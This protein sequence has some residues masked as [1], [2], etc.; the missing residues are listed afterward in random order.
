MYFLYHIPG[1]KIGVTRNLFIRVTKQ[2]GYKQNEYEVLEQSDDID[3]ISKREIELQKQYGYRKDNK[4]Y[5]QL[6]KMK[7]N[8]TEQTTTFPCPKNKLKGN[9]MDNIGLTWTTQFGEHVISHKNILWIQKNSYGS[10]YDP[11]RCF[12][13]NKAFYEETQN[14]CIDITFDQIRQWAEK[15]GIIDEGDIKTQYVKLQEEIGEL[16]QAILQDRKADIIDAI[17]DATV[18]L[19]NLASLAG[20]NIEH[21]IN[22]AYSEISNRTGN[23]V[24]G[25]FVKDTKK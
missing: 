20:T 5:K 2:Q 17:G 11:N 24:N 8:V 6:F 14:E 13:Y 12:I 1:K 10:M 18:V 9:L 21:C 7:V 15:R 22:T 25:T 19:T 23:M 4:L 16:A 3:Y